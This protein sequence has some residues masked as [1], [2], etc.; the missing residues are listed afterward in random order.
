MHRGSK[1]S[2]CAVTPSMCLCLP[3]RNLTVADCTW[4]QLKPIRLTVV[5]LLPFSWG[6]MMDDSL[7]DVLFFLFLLFVEELFQNVAFS[8]VLFH[9][10]SVLGEFCGCGH[11][12]PVCNVHANIVLVADHFIIQ[13]ILLSNTTIC[14]TNK[15]VE[16]QNHKKSQKKR[17]EEKK[18][19]S[20]GSTGAAA[21][22][23][24]RDLPTTSTGYQPKKTVTCGFWWFYPSSVVPLLFY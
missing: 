5:D 1:W 16:T 14:F 22:S 9:F 2:T 18:W 10:Q 23:F 4:E 8:V 3:S 12:W 13:H 7:E 17:W 19:Q 15:V 6:S 20:A 21:G 11:Q 24:F